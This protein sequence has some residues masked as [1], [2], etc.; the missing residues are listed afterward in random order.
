MAIQIQDFSEPLTLVARE[1]S[2]RRVLIQSEEY[3]HLVHE[4]RRYCN[5][6]I[7][8]RSFLIA[9]HRGSGKTTF[10]LSAFEQIWRESEE[11][12]LRMRPLLVPLLGPSLLPGSDE[13]DV[14]EPAAGAGKTEKRLTPF[15]N[16]LVQFTLALH[17]AVVN[18]LAQA[19]RERMEALALRSATGAV[20]DADR[21]AVCLEAPGQLA[22]ELDEYPGKSRLREFWRR[23]GALPGGVLPV[24]RRTPPPNVAEFSNQ[25]V[26]ELVALCSVSE[27]YRR[28]SG[29]IQAK[30]KDESS[31]KNS[32]T[33]TRE[34]ELKGKDLFAPLITLLTGGAVTAGVAALSDKHLSIAAIAG[35]LTALASAVV[36]KS[37]IV[38]SR[39]RSASREDLFLPNLSVSTLDR[40]FPVLLDRVRDAGLAPVFV[41]DE[42]DK[43]DVSDRIRDMVKRLK[44][45]VAEKAFFCFLTD[46]G[47]FEELSSRNAVTPHSLESTYF[48]N[49]VFIAFRHT[50]FHDFIKEL[51]IKPET[52]VA[53]GPSSDLQSRLDQEAVDHALLPFILMH[54]AEMHPIDL[55]RQISSIRAPDGTVAL[56][57]HQVGSSLNRLRVYLQVALELML[58]SD[59]MTQE[60]AR[61]PTFRRLAHDALYF[62]SRQ[63]QLDASEMRID[64]KGCD[65]FQA[66]LVTRM[67]PECISTDSGHNGLRADL[68][69]P[70]RKGKPKTKTRTPKSRNGAK[71]PQPLLSAKQ[72]DFLWTQ[73]CR[74]VEFLAGPP[75]GV[76]DQ[77]VKKPRFAVPVL[78][79]L[80]SISA[81]F[82]EQIG[83]YVFRFRYDRAGREIK[84]APE[85]AT[86]GAA[87]PAHGETEPVRPKLFPIQ[88]EKAFIQEFDRAL[89]ELTEDAVNLGTLGASFGVIA[90][91]P[92]WSVVE[93]ALKRL[94]NGTRDYPEKQADILDVR[95]FA[96]VLRRSADTMRLAIFCGWVL[97]A[98]GGSSLKREA[99]GLQILSQAL[100]LKTAPEDAARLRIDQFT[101]ELMTRLKV[102]S[103]PTQGEI[104][105]VSNIK[106]WENEVR[107]LQQQAPPD[108][109]KALEI[110]AEVEENAWAFWLE[111]LR[112]ADAPVTFEAV[113]CAAARKGPSSLLDFP[114]EDMT[115]RAW[116]IAFHVG[117]KGPTSP[118]DRVPEWLAPVALRRLRFAVDR[119]LLQLLRIPEPKDLPV[120]DTAIPDAGVQPKRPGRALLVT[121]DGSESEKWKVTTDCPALLLRQAELQELISSHAKDGFFNALG[122]EWLAFDWSSRST[123]TAL[124][125]DTE[126]EF[127]KNLMETPEIA[128]PAT[129]VPVIVPADWRETLAPFILP[130]QAPGSFDELFRK[131]ARETFKSSPA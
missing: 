44:K 42:L 112:R 45:L 81:P 97:G 21:I 103:P 86:A 63:W 35:V 95:Q 128:V 56:Q 70:V 30:T 52:S 88:R 38:R 122:I 110:T 31:A 3:N 46:R 116:S 23:A 127:A 36:A 1:S 14:A 50:E 118:I 83:R 47:Y 113:L 79:V 124:A 6:Q 107:K 84:V 33:R 73:V 13:R 58:E 55:R 54:K 16:V 119:T 26:N 61:D 8:G 43:I 87:P 80:R 93:V 114:P 102:K 131:V 62:V 9:G 49:Q 106:R 18:E 96:D 64:K 123:P 28:I 74:L 15:E 41:I 12:T 32:R 22:L 53:P 48:S 17:R 117:A 89:R 66:Y 98:L 25:G 115:A 2:V 105:G 90:T 75:G 4:L 69:A 40:V 29:T 109:R 125:S 10:T 101:V 51:L 120:A 20:S 99:G 82:L 68:N 71:M 130:I 94:G 92:S 59:E 72:A 108:L 57:S 34:T 39:Q 100:G 76:H 60:L 65:E 11:G 67:T 129:V 104:S 121:R 7:S 91:S 85:P 111:R 126:I 19:Y 27:A 78:D 24:R 5:G 77:A 37:S